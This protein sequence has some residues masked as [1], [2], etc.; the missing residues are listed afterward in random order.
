LGAR[1]W[2][3]KI[4][5][6]ARAKEPAKERSQSRRAGKESESLPKERA[7]LPNKEPRGAER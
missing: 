1:N 2:L 5:S 7:K 3:P 6:G 4:G